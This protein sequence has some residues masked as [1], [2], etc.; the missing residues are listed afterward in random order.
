MTETK[1]KL[2]KGLKRGLI[3]SVAVPVLA[4]AAAFTMAQ[5]GYTL[6][7]NLTPSV[8]VGLYIANRNHGTVELGQLVGFYPHND[9]AQH[10]FREGWMKPG[11]WYVKR[12]GAVAGDM[13]CVDKELTIRT[14]GQ[15]APAQFVRVGPVA[16]H[17]RTGK[18]LPHVLAG[19]QR[20]PA[21]QFLPVGD[22]VPNSF[23]GRYYGFVPVSKIEATLRP[24][25]T[26]NPTEE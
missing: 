22:G 18:P 19:C 20:V 25:W 4:T 12:V 11:S 9:A 2:R 1:T 5:A 14:A 16:Q 26:Q 21:G 15:G 8:P 3:M 17:D 7:A 10:G 6:T 23:D 24:L 13:V